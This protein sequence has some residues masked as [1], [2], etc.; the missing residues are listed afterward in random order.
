MDTIA[1]IA[2][3]LG[4]GGIGIIR[5]SGPRAEELLKG[6]F[7][8]EKPI[9]RYIS[10]RLYLGEIRD[11]QSNAALDQVLACLMKAPHSYTGEDVVEISCHGGPMVL[12]KIL[13]VVVKGGARH[14]EPGEFTKR[15]FLNG[16]LDLTQ[17]EAVLDLVRSR[18]ERSHAQAMALLKG[19]LSERL[20]GIKARLLDVLANV[21]AAIDF[22]EE[23]DTAGISSEELLGGMEAVATEMLSLIKTYEEGKTCRE[24]ISAAIV[25]RPNVGK[26]S[27]FN[28]LLNEDRAIVTELPGTTR[29]YI[30]ET[31]SIEGYPVRLLDTAGLGAGRE[32]IE[33][34]G[35]KLTREK[36]GH[37]DILLAVFDGSEPLKEE[38]IHLINEVR[39]RKKILV[40]NKADLPLMLSMENLSSNCPGIDPVVVSAKKRTGL[41]ALKRRIITGVSGYGGE[42]IQGAVITRQRHRDALVR[43]L[44]ATRQAQEG[45]RKGVSPE[46]A[47][48]DLRLSLEALGEVVGETSTEDLLNRIFSEFCI[49]K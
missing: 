9:P 3:P 21:E 31:V 16:R 5:I 14:A 32:R 1:A 7:F 47:S 38:D 27:L 42:P 35:M 44:D 37:S 43:A 15:A 13:N 41:D 29:D 24:G 48:V 26:S 19:A 6:V 4:E 39:E 30:E 46:L 34:E 12:R 20:Q 36:I 17:A 28:A 18:T 45:V 8:P 11:P 10:R 40:V 2:T 25:G 22:P 49:G 23:E 33:E